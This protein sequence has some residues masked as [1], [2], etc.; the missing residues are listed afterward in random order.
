MNLDNLPRKNSAD[1]IWVDYIE[2]LCLFNRDGIVTKA[3][4]LDRR[5]DEADF[6]VDTEEAEDN[7]EEMPVSEVKD[8]EE[9]EVDDWFRHLSYRQG[10]FHDFYPFL[11]GSDGQTCYRHESL[12]EKHK[13]YIFLLLASNLRYFS[14]RHHSLTRTFEIVSWAALKEF[15]PAS[16]EVHIFRPVSEMRTSQQRYV[17]NLWNRM[18]ILATDLRERLRI[19]QIH[20]SPNDSGDGGLDIVGWVPTGNDSTGGLLCVFAQCACTNDWVD[21]QHSSGVQAWGAKLTFTCPPSN[22]VF[23]PFCFRNAGGEWFTPHDIHGSILVDRVRLVY[24]LRE[25]YPIWMTFSAY[26]FIEEQLRRNEAL[27]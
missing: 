13:F 1:H 21:K 20:L 16:A 5:R 9:R 22:M 12:S 8:V 6:Y 26:Q 3:D 24:F 19:E 2:L 10:V 18:N 14:G 4:V 17:G 25:N 11:V 7:W 27:V 23:I 15:L